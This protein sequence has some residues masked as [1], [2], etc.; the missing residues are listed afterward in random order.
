MPLSDGK[1][2]KKQSL[3]LNF[4]NAASVS[5]VPYIYGNAD[6]LLLKIYIFHLETYLLS[7]TKSFVSPTYCCMVCKTQWLVNEMNNLPHS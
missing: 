6:F 2:V 7:W 3:I 1:T 4:D 5:Q